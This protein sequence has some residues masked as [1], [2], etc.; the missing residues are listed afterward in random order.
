M[1]KEKTNVNKKTY[2][3]NINAERDLLEIFTLVKE[4]INN[5]YTNL[6]ERNLIFTDGK[7]GL[8][9]FLDVKNIEEYEKI[10]DNNKIHICKCILYK[11]RS[12]DFPYLFDILTGQK[13]EINSNNSDTIMEQTHFIMIPELKVIISE[14]NHFG[15]QPTK[16]PAVIQKV[17]GEA[18]VNK[19]EVK[20]MLNTET[21]YRLRNLKDVETISIKCGHQG[22]KTVNHYFN[23]NF[24]DVMEKGFR[25]TEDLEFKFTISGKGRGANKKSIE[26]EDESKFK[27]FCNLLFNS[28]N[29]KNLDIHSAKI[30]ER[31]TKGKLEIKELPIDLF[32]DY[33]VEEVTAVRLSKKSKYIDS[34]DMFKKLLEL[35]NEN[36]FEF[37]DYG[38]IKLE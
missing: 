35:Y 13:T 4:K 36:K 10:N 17:L 37:S 23:V 5:N 1:D 8:K 32:S 9:Y 3:Y 34:D 31:R 19:L 21:A 6:D 11:L 33:F 26:L 14:Y 2:A 25:N 24:L 30:N 12:D 16:I 18:Y 38:K 22:L 27:R 20:H 15:A 28:K 29:K 7:N